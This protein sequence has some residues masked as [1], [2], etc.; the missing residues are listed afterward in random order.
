METKTFLA[1]FDGK[2]VK[3]DEPHQLE[4]GAKLL[5]TVLSKESVSDEREDGLRI[6]AHRLQ[7]A[8]GEEEI[9]YSRSLIKE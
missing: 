6:S 9:E 1:H 2:E 5:V 7:Y 8:Y 4:P 3:F